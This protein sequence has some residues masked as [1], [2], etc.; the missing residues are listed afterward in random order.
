[1]GNAQLYSKEI[2]VVDHQKIDL[3]PKSCIYYYP[4]KLKELQVWEQRETKHKYRFKNQK[5]Q[6]AVSSVCSQQK[7]IQFHGFV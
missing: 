7:Q 1:M 3:F 2:G 6:E 4:G 5:K